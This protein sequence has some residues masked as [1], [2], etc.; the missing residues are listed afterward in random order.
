MGE[1]VDTNK[2]ER[3]VGLLLDRVEECTDMGAAEAAQGWAE[4]LSWVI[5]SKALYDG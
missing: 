4:V 3:V 5:Q 1:E 2:W